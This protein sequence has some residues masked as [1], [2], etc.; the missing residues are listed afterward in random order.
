MHSVLLEVS[1]RGHPAVV[2]RVCRFLTNFIV[3]ETRMDEMVVLAAEWWSQSIRLGW[4]LRLALV[5]MHR[6]VL[7]GHRGSTPC[8]SML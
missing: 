7:G 4:G 2:R 5:G 8:G 1:A 6:S 3:M